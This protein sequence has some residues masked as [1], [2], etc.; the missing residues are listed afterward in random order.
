MEF[1]SFKVT[2]Q[3]YRGATPARMARLVP[4]RPRRVWTPPSGRQPASR[5]APRSQPSSGNHHTRRVR[6][7]AGNGFHF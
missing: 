6:R 2:D 5:P 1:T 4:S 7:R 3:N